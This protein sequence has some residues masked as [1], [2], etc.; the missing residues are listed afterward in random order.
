M[1]TH[2]FN[3]HQNTEKMSEIQQQWTGK[4]AVPSLLIDRRTSTI[5]VLIFCSC[6]WTISFFPAHQKN[7]NS[8]SHNLINEIM[9]H[10][11]FPTVL[12]VSE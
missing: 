5:V 11:I 10:Y 2:I 6:S 3:Q 12:G 1:L 8:E 4:G 9:G 7:L